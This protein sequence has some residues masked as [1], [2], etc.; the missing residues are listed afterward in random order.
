[1]KGINSRFAKTKLTG[2][3][4]F[5]LG[6]MAVGCGGE[7]D[8]GGGS[9]QARSEPSLMEAYSSSFLIGTA[10]NARQ[11][12]GE[13]PAEIQIVERHFNSV[14][15]KNEMKWERIHPEP[16][17][18]D[19]EMADRLVEFAERN[20]MQVVGHTLVW[21]NQTP[22]WV[23]QDRDGGQVGRDTLLAR[24]KDHI[25][26]VVGRYRGR[27]A[28]WDVVN[29]ALNADGSRRDSPWRQIIGD[30]YIAKAFEF[31][32]EADPDAE[33]YYND[34]SLPNEEKRDGAVALIADLQE[35][36]APVSAIGLQ[37]HYSLDWPTQDQLSAA[38][39]AFAGL[40]IDVMITELDIDVLP[41]VRSGAEITDT[42][43]WRA[44]IDP[45]K[46]GLPETVERQLTQ[47]YADLFRSFVEYDNVISRVTLW[48]VTDANSWKNYWP[49]AGRTN[50]P[51]LF[52]REGDPKPAFD[53]VIEVANR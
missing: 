18:Y 21:H 10:L 22:E 35:R 1:M 5:L 52:D 29:E 23:F 17:R 12:A 50:Y 53:A 38:I 41:P 3:V 8:G 36:G 49:V 30:D 6:W 42:A 4:L 20:G 34:Y 13:E 25:M 33:L 14:T 16:G 40:G 37:G 7:A 28:G 48:G 9:N 32:H 44:E 45:Y 47:R 11:I 26:T 2:L 43:S 27:V 31:A 15:G 39:E 24:M 51:L 46:D 19:F